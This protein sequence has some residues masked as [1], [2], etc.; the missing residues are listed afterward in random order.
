MFSLHPY[1][2]SCFLF[3]LNVGGRFQDMF[4]VKKKELIN[5]IKADDFYRLFRKKTV[6]VSPILLDSRV[7]PTILNYAL[8]IEGK[9]VW[10][11]EQH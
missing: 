6:T 10:G 7:A 9:F 4:D 8:S 2:A 3:L 11:T 1:T 5:A